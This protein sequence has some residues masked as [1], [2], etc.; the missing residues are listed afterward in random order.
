MDKNKFSFH[1]GVHGVA[2][3]VP[4]WSDGMSNEYELREEAL[5]LCRADGDGILAAVGDTE[6]WLQLIPFANSHSSDKSDHAQQ[7]R[8][9]EKKLGDLQRE[10]RRSSRRP[11]TRG[12]QKNN[13]NLIAELSQPLTLPDTSKD[14]GKNR[15]GDGQQKGHNIEV[16][17]HGAGGH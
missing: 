11:R 8:A 5:G 15:K 14:E 13:N 10:V 17:S 6:H 1:N 3:L 12:L 7:K 2:L 4:K 9:M 16:P